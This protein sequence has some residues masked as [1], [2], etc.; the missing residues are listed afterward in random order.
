MSKTLQRVLISIVMIL[1]YV[2]LL[3][4]GDQGKFIY[5]L[6]GNF[7]VGWLIWELADNIIG[8]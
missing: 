1:V 8:K 3:S 4:L 2:S 5:T 6:I 7:A